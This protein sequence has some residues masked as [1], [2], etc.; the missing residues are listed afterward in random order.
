MNPHNKVGCGYVFG[1]VRN[2][3]ILQDS[4]ILCFSILGRIFVPLFLTRVQQYR[5]IVNIFCAFFFFLFWEESLFFYLLQYASN[6]E[7]INIREISETYINFT[8]AA[9]FMSGHGE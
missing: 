3:I 6:T 5:T 2:T 9:S 7:R 8:K 1:I 4:Y